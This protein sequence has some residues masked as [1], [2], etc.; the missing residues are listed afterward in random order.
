MKTKI[1]KYIA[2]IYTNINCDDIKFIGTVKAD[3]IHE[4]KDKARAHARSWNEHGGKL[5]LECE[6]TGREWTINS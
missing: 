1:Y 3:S 4:L 2:K 6:N 5:H